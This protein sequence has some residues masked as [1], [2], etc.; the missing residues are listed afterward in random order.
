MAS[1]SHLCLG[2]AIDLSQRSSDRRN[3]GH[4]STILHT[5]RAI[6]HDI[7]N[8]DSSY[9]CVPDAKMC[10]SAFSR[11]SG[12]SV[13]M[14][15]SLLEIANVKNFTT[16]S[17]TTSLPKRPKCDNSFAF[18]S[19]EYIALL[20]ASRMAWVIRCVYFVTSLYM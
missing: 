4:D 16:L 10:R 5:W 19:S 12:I 3:I 8:D 11:T 6:V 20:A 2:C 14:T 17:S 18:P 13:Y 1:Y 9:A 15:L 7:C